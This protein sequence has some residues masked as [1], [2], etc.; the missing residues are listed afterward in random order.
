[1][2]I[3]ALNRLADKLDGTGLYA[4]DGPIVE[5]F[6]IGIWSLDNKS[7][8]FVACAIGH[9]C[10]DDW[11]DLKI[12]NGTPW[13]GGLAGWT[14]VVKYFSLSTTGQAIFL[15]DAPSYSSGY[16]TEAADVAKRIREFV[17]DNS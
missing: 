6:D 11:F 7:C 15:F 16:S 4:E 13:Y 10:A 1:M 17:A 8:G 2:N 5:S 14:G 9:A 12:V 3:E